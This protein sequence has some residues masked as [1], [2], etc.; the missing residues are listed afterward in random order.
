M[1]LGPMHSG[2]QRGRRSPM[3]EITV[4]P[5][6]DVMLVLLIIF[7]VP[8]PLLTA[9]VQVDLPD[10]KAAPL[11]QNAEPVTISIDA[12]RQGY[13]HETPVPLDAADA[14]IQRISA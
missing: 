11:E 3:A 12:Q 13:I 1:S 10:S 2:G 7:R 4:P 14:H 9:G 6:V 8:A 5:M